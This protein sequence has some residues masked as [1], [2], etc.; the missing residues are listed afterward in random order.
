MSVSFAKWFIPSEAELSD[1]TE[2]QSDVL[3]VSNESWPVPSSEQIH[4]L[5]DNTIV[6][7]KHTP[8]KPSKPESYRPPKRVWFKRKPRQLKTWRRKTERFSLSDVSN[9]ESTLIN[10]GKVI[11]KQKAR[12][13][14]PF[15]SELQSTLDAD[16]PVTHT[17]SLSADSE[18]TY[19]LNNVTALLSKNKNHAQ[20]KTWNEQN[21]TF[22]QAVERIMK[23]DDMSGLAT[24]IQQ[25]FQERLDS[26]GVATYPNGIPANFW[27]NATGTMN[28]SMKNVTRNPIPG[29]DQNTQDANQQQQSSG[30]DNEEQQSSGGDSEE[31]SGS[32]ATPQPQT[33]WDEFS[34]M[35]KKLFEEQTID[36]LEWNSLT[37]SQKTSMAKYLDTLDLN[38][39]TVEE[40]AHIEDLLLKAP[41]SSSGIKNIQAIAGAIG[42]LV[43]ILVVAMIFKNRKTKGSTRSVVSS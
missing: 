41:K 30:G 9:L 37:D 21:A 19:T 40:Q 17:V 22:F 14:P 43:T 36:G 12:E 39:L 16:Y 7:T 25:K 13:M 34:D 1:W 2:G 24:M 5:K 20:R 38:Q 26:V 10:L 11:C 4:A 31:Q 32:D 15:W 18:I 35:R 6:T 23:S 29:N 27:D 42:I 3:P 8:N 33:D 28:D